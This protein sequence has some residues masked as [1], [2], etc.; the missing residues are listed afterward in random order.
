MD[1]GSAGGRWQ[2]WWAVAAMVAVAPT[3]AI[4]PAEVGRTRQGRMGVIL[5]DG[6]I[7]PPSAIATIAAATKSEFKDLTGP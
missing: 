1:G 2:H 4:A 5:S 3:E 6:T 7:A